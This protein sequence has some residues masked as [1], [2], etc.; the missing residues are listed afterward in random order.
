[1]AIYAEVGEATWARPVSQ[2]GVNTFA[3][4]HQW[5]EQTNMLAFEFTHELRNDA[6]RCLWLDRCTVMYAVLRA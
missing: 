4:Y 5:A 6:L 1:M 2:L 3:V